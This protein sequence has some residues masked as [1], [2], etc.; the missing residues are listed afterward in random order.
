MARMLRRVCYANVIYRFDNDFL[1]FN[2]IM[3]AILESIISYEHKGATGIL[4]NQL[5]PIYDE[6]KFEV[7]APVVRH[8]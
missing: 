2:V 7:T 5:S 4:S 1:A 6:R 8:G 3:G